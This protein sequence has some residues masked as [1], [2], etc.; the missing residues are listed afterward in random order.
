MYI[1]MDMGTSNTRLWLCD[2]KSIIDFKKANFGAKLGKLEGKAVLFERLQTLINTLLLANKKS[3]EQIDC[4]I[5]SGMSGSEIGLCDIPHIDLPSDIYK[6]ATNLSVTVIPEITD[7]PF[8]F[9]PGVKQTV[10]GYLTD[11]MRGEETEVFGILPHLPLNTP[12]TVILPGTHNKIIQVNEK[13]EIINFKTTISGEL[14]DIIINNSILSGSVSHRFVISEID[15]LNGAAYAR[16][17]GLNAAIFHIRVMAKN[18]ISSDGLSSFLYGAVLGEDVTTISKYAN[19]GSVYIGGNEILQSVYKI[20]LKDIPAISLDRTVADMAVVSGLQ[21]IYYIRKA[22]NLREN[23]LRA[24]EREKLI[25]IV[26]SPDKDTLIPAIQ[27]LYDGGVRLLEITFDRSGKLSR[28]EICSM[29]SEISVTFNGSM[30]VGAGTVTSCEEVKAAFHAGALFIISPNCDPEIITLTRKLGMVSI[31]A[32]YTAT[33]IA[34]ALKYGA[35]Y[36]KL[37]PADQVT[38]EYVKAI[39]APLSDAKLLAVGG[40]TAENAKAFLDMGFYGIGVGSN[41]YNKHLINAKNYKS[42]KE[43]AKKYVAAINDDVL[44]PPQN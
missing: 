8:W 1:A 25:S 6:E 38:K 16:S 14:L 11:I 32:A 2:E 3:K 39:T 43:L 9:V 22:H 21:N 26:R 37:F 19:T 42:L 18:G 23:T 4:I 20:L 27:A 12:A 36:I 28:D 34:T 13:G 31:P 24:I 30:L 10:D 44:Y 33:E 41:L 35:D 7:I 17:N 40:V 29:I 15:V 5:T